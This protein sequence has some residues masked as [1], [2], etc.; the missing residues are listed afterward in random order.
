MFGIK[1]FYPSKKEKLLWEPIRFAKRH[2]S[3]TNKDI[4]SIFHPRKLFL[5]YN[6]KTWVKKSRNH[7]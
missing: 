7:L 5:Y 1:E 4:E 3:I 6:N 2:I